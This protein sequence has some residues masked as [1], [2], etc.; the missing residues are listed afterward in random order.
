ME[1]TGAPDPAAIMAM[2]SEMDPETRRE[3]MDMASSMSRDGVERRSYQNVMTFSICSIFM[4][5]T[6]CKLKEYVTYSMM[7]KSGDP[8]SQEAIRENWELQKRRFRH[9][10]PLLARIRAGGGGPNTVLFTTTYRDRI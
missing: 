2:L 4:Q 8:S 5:P 9:G 3:A 6:K 7:P 10:N 1:V